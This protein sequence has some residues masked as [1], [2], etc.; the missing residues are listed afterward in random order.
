MSQESAYSSLMRY[1]DSYGTSQSSEERSVPQLPSPRRSVRRSP[2]KSA[3]TEYIWEDSSRLQLNVESTRVLPRQSAIEEVGAELKEK[4]QTL[5]TEIQS[6]KRAAKELQQEYLRLSIVKERKI[7]RKK[8]QMESLLA[9]QEKGQND[10]LQKQKQFF[11]KVNI[12]VNTLEKKQTMLEEQMRSIQTDAEVQLHKAANASKLK[13]ARALRQLE[14]EEKQAIDKV[15]QSK[16]PAMQKSA[17]DSFGPKL[18][19]LVKNG[20]ME[21]SRLAQENEGIFCKYDDSLKNFI[22]NS[23]KHEPPT[24]AAALCAR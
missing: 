4:V 7:E 10:G 11:E 13:K 17:A 21:L 15:I 8:Q 22:F 1:L 18:D 23:R 16:L 14:A 3:S 19:A 9:E 20:K 6:N 2:T 12:D 24:T 5:K